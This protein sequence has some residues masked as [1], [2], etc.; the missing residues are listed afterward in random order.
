MSKKIAR[1]SV[2]SA[3][4]LGGLPVADLVGAAWHAISA[5]ASRRDPNETAAAADAE[6]AIASHR[7]LF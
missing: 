3:C 6:F 1:P 5:T 2:I 4:A 7:V